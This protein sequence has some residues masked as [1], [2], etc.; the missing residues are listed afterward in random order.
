VNARGRCALIAFALTLAACGGTQQSTSSST[1]TPSTT[2]APTT[3]TTGAPAT[4]TPPPS[5]T[6]APQPGL[7]LEFRQ[8]TED[9]EEYSYNISYPVLVDENGE[10]V[11]AANNALLTWVDETVAEVQAAADALDAKATL[12]AQ[13]APELLNDSVLSLSG[14]STRFVTSGAGTVSRRHG[15]IVNLETG[16]AVTAAE[17]MV[18][19]DLSPLAEAARSHLIAVL[20]SE[21]AL[22][23]P[24]GLLPVPANFDAAWLTATG[25][26]VGFDEGQ[27]AAPSAGSPAV[28]I[29]FA[30][31]DVFLIKKGVLAP[32]SEADR[33]PEI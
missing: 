11:A 19:G 15:W 29:P 24:D 32:L 7:S 18:D 10:A 6:V 31:L 2:G 16:A 9:T 12:T 17:M 3:T 33:L 13:V 27:V 25:I 14:V 4:T 8:A 28:S 1:V 21:D 30:E 26:G 20:G 5:T 22:A 23:G